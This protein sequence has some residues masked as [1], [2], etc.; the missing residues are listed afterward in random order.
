MVSD[1]VAAGGEI[2]KAPAGIPRDYLQAKAEL[3][4]TKDRRAIDPSF[5]PGEQSHLRQ[6]TAG[7]GAMP[8]SEAI[9]MPAK[10]LPGRRIRDDAR[11]GNARS[12][13]EEVER[14]YRGHYFND[15]ATASARRTRKKST[16]SSSNSL[17][18]PRTGLNRRGN[19]AQRVLDRCRAGAI[20]TN[21]AAGQ[22]VLRA[23][24]SRSIAEEDVLEQRARMVKRLRKRR[25]EHPK[26]TEPKHQ[27]LERRRR[28]LKR[29]R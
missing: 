6:H 16:I 18:K 15:S 2:R 1:Y 12:H 11:I 19:C 20:D 21:T 27:R 13:K 17:I 10:P 29:H 28:I 14:L 23:E 8:R 9:A 25:K 22:G 5:T 7:A 24:K 4:L 26:K 3:G